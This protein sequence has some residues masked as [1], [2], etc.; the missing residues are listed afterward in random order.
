MMH[1][2]HR[3]ALFSVLALSVI[4][5]A[6]AYA[7]KHCPP[8]AEAPAPSPGTDEEDHKEWGFKTFIALVSAGLVSGARCN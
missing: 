7:H 2:Y 1:T 8:P 4:V 6:A 3:T 5:N